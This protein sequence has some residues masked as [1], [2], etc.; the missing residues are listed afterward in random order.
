[1]RFSH[2]VSGDFFYQTFR[3]DQSE[4]VESRLFRLG[5]LLRAL[6]RTF[7]GSFFCRGIP[8][9]VP[10]TPDQFKRTGRYDLFGLTVTFGAFD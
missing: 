8:I 7:F 1:M 10:S 6:G 4:E 9:S 2:K 3:D 5:F